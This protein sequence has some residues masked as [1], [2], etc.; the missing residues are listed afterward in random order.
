MVVLVQLSQHLQAYQWY[1]QYIR[2]DT[3]SQQARPAYIKYLFKKVYIGAIEDKCVD[4][5]QCMKLDVLICW[6][7]NDKEQ[8]KTAVRRQ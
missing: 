4:L 2:H 8:V 5:K 1:I 7:Q 6:Q 3:E